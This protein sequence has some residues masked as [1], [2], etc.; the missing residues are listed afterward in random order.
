MKSLKDISIKSTPAA[1]AVL[2]ILA[3]RQT[4]IDINVLIDELKAKNISVN[5]AT[6]YRIIN[7]FY[8]KGIVSRIELGEGKYR[9]ELQKDDHHHLICTNCGRIEDVEDKFMDK[10]EKEIRSKTGFLIKSHSL[11]FFGLCK[12]CQE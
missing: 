6:I 1:S 4:P 10:I 8:E 3:N 5:P 11:E 2:S 7:K 9:Y 12:N